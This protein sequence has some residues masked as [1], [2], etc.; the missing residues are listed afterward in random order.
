MQFGT[1]LLEPD[2][3]IGLTYRPTYIQTNMQHKHS[4]SPLPPPPKTGGNTIKHARHMHVIGDQF[5]PPL[6]NCIRYCLTCAGGFRPKFPI[7]IRM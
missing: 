5:D 1:Q 6:V 2:S 7:H 3:G 4:I